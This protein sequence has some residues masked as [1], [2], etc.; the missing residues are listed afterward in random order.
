[1]KLIVN[2]Q[3]KHNH[4]SMAIDILQAATCLF[5]AAITYFLFFRKEKNCIESREFTKEEVSNF[6]QVIEKNQVDKFQK[7]IQHCF[8]AA[9]Q[10]RGV[11]RYL[12]C[13]LCLGWNL[14]KNLKTY[15]EI[16]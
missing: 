1:M 15:A 13:L 3:N 6:F 11:D 8:L 9:A 14:V 2:E 5:I 7:I 16:F 4:I 10:G 12:L